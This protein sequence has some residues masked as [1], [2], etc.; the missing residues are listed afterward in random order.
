MTKHERLFYL[1]VGVQVAIR[2]FATD[3]TTPR[4][5]LLTQALC[6]ALVF[7]VAAWKVTAEDK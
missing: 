5:L 3:T 7:A 6:L 2:L 1:L 4:W